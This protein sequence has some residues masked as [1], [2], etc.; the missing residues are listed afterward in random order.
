[1]PRPRLDDAAI[2]DALAA[3]PQW[4]R[5]GESLAREFAFPTFRA[6][7]A[8]V[9]QVADAAEAARHHPDIDIRYTKVTL[10]YWTHDSGGI[11]QS[12]I[13]AAAL[14]S[15]MFDGESR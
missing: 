14:V 13:K 7:L 15:E 10:L 9:N 5:R 4:T 1:M 3:L 11:T 6:A 8:F 2:A 12:D